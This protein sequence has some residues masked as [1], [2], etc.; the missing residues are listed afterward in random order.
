[1]CNIFQQRFHVSLHVFWPTNCVKFPRPQFQEANCHKSA[2]NPLTRCNLPKL[3]AS[4]VEPCHGENKILE[5]QM[6]HVAEW[7][8][9]KK[10]DKHTL[11]LCRHTSDPQ[12]TILLMSKGMGKANISRKVL[13]RSD[14]KFG[15][16]NPTTAF[17]QVVW[18]GHTEQPEDEGAT[19]LQWFTKAYHKSRKNSDQ[20]VHACRG[21]KHSSAASICHNATKVWNIQNFSW[22]SNTPDYI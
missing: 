12:V 13:S 11:V 22:D 6:E 16:S 19:R 20:W 21:W 7:K 4:V 18:S 2:A 10:H 8:A 3:F 9:V 17:L 15:R 14:P 1:M 5:T